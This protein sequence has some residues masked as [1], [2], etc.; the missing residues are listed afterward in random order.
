M[1]FL[2]ACGR[3]KL[4][5]HILIHVCHTSAKNCRRIWSHLSGI[6]RLGFGGGGDDDADGG[7]HSCDRHFNEASLNAPC[8]AIKYLKANANTHAF[9]WMHNGWLCMAVLPLVLRRAC[10]A[11]DWH[12]NANANSRFPL[13]VFSAERFSICFCLCCWFILLL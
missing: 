12:S 4:C 10:A 13:E 2:L 7:L 3:S 1:S 6:Y 8:R 9:I 11:Y 5:I